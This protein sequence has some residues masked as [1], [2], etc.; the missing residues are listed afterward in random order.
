[1]KSKE[2]DKLWIKIGLDEEIISMPPYVIPI[3]NG[4]MQDNSR[5][6]KIGK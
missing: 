4:M 3:Q 5:K 2:F 1:M 6:D